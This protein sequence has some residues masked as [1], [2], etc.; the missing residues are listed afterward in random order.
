MSTTWVNPTSPTLTMLFGKGGVDMF[1]PVPVATPTT[2]RIYPDTISLGG[3][4]FT[5]NTSFEPYRR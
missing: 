4:P 5:I 2:P 3:R 1:Y